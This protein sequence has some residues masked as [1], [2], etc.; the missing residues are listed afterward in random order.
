MDPCGES[1]QRTSPLSVVGAVVL[2]SVVSHPSCLNPADP[3]LNDPEGVTVEGE[4]PL[5]QALHGD[6]FVL[7]WVDRELAWGEQIQ[8]ESEEGAWSV[9]GDFGTTWLDWDPAATYRWV[10]PDQ[11]VEVE[12]TELVVEVSA[13]DQPA[14]YNRDEAILRDVSWAGADLSGLSMALV[15]ERDGEGWL[16]ARCEDGEPCW[17][18]EPAYW[19]R[20]HKRDLPDQL[21]VGWWAELDEPGVDPVTISIEVVR[22]EVGGSLAS[23]P[24]DVPQTG[25]TVLWGDVHSHSNLSY[26]GCE[27]RDNDCLPR[28]DR[29][30]DD[31]YALAAEEGLDFLAVT[32]HAEFSTY[33]RSD[34]GLSLS[35][36]EETLALA[37]AAEEQGEI[38]PIVA[39]EWTGLYSIYDHETG[40]LDAAGGHRTVVLDSLDPCEEYWI[41]ASSPESRKDEVG[42]ERYIFRSAIFGQPDE[43]QDKMAQAANNCG[44]VRWMSWFHHSGL[45]RPRSV[46]WEQQVNRDLGD[47]LVEIYS[48]H[49]SSECW[50]VSLDGC[51]WSVDTQL[52]VSS[53]SIQNA[54]QIGYQL[55]FVAGTDS[56]DGRPG[57]VDDGP[58]AIVGSVGDGDEGYHLQFASGGVT[59]VLAA[60]EEPER[61]DIFDALELRNTYAASWLFDEVRV[62]AL[63]QDGEVYLPG[64]EVPEAASPLDLMVQIEDGVVESWQI[65]LLDAENEAWLVAEHS[66][67]DEPFDI[68]AGEVRY[69]RVRA[70]MQ[71]QEHRLWASPFF[72][73]E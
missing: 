42:I 13:V 24:V 33:N 27:D 10:G 65:E 47:V 9:L 36:W 52:A 51:E 70:W 54:L 32:D 63:G 64:D 37:Q 1:M 5:L 3:E 44:E 72:G 16:E 29:P 53:G 71:D 49:G 25:R 45:Q 56:H 18:D 14:V 73:V 7:V 21:S 55:G 67:L 11:E 38:I 39:Y 28:G 30:G 31:L 61:E 4:P 22:H 43:M 62:A 60:G 6:G 58:G 59:G 66:R 41:G 8:R 40:N 15:V 68:A 26:D 57:S 46:D 17:R 69:V 20:W 12:P 35:I 23:V 2:I 50:D 19:K 34:I 48:E